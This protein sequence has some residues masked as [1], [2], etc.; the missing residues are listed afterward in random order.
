MISSR[1]SGAPFRFGVK[2]AWTCKENVWMAIGKTFTRSA[3]NQS[4]RRQEKHFDSVFHKSHNIFTEMGHD[5]TTK[6]EQSGI[7]IGIQERESESLKKIR[8]ISNELPRMCCSHCPGTTTVRK[9]RAHNRSSR[10]IH[11]WLHFSEYDFLRKLKKPS[12]NVNCKKQNQEIRRDLYMY[13][14]S[15]VQS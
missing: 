15:I 12:L 14:L 3:M 11:H 9:F 1:S 13:V 10:N 7:E 2:Y 8:N 6:S 4:G 5:F